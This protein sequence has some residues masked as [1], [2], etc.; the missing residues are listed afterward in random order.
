MNKKEFKIL[1][2]RLL[3]IELEG[4]RKKF[5][6]YR[7]RPFL[8]NNIVIKRDKKY[9][10]KACLAYYE[11][12][13]E[14]KRQREYTHE[15]FITKLAIEDYEIYLKWHWKRQG[16]SKLR[17]IIRHELIHAFVFEEFEE[18]GDLEDSYGDYSPIFLSCLYWCGGY[19][20]HPYTYKFLETDLY[21]EIEN[22]KKYEQVYMHLIHYIFDIEKTVRNINEKLQKD[23]KNYKRLKIE[24]NRY[25]AGIVKRKYISVSTTTKKDNMLYRQ[26]VAEMTLGLGFLVTSKVLLQG[27]ERKFSNGSIASSHAEMVGYIVNNELKQKVTVIDK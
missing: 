18:W 6:P 26:K 15:I 23:I 2:D 5:K 19:T 13:R 24:F 10:K 12:T 11:N 27:Y 7:R 20:G 4:L 22:C 16:I 9:S 21:K 17:E 8:N 3:T 25:G 14:N 1:M